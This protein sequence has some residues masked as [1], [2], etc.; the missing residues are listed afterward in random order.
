MPTRRSC[1]RRLPS[2][3]K[4]LVIEKKTRIS[5]GLQRY[6]IVRRYGRVYFLVSNSE[7][8]GLDDRR[9]YWFLIL[10]FFSTTLFIL[11]FFGG[12][13]CLEEWVRSYHDKRVLCQELEEHLHAPEAAF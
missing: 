11:L 5:I 3:G 10:D 8:N 13:R 7:K 6:E 1:V 2:E 4:I 12:E 9:L